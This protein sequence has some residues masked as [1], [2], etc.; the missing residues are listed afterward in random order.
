MKAITYRANKNGERCVNTALVPGNHT[1]S[2]NR[3]S[4][5]GLAIAGIL[6]LTTATFV[7]AM[8]FALTR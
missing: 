8:L 1:E 5:V 7:G 3:V 4:G 2:M 6:L